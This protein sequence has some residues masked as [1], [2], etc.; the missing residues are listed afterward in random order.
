[1]S[2][3][4]RI[5]S[6]LILAVL[7]CD[8]GKTD[9]LELYIAVVAPARAVDLQFRS[10]GVLVTV[11]AQPGVQVKKG[12]LVAE[13]DTQALQEEL[14][15]AE[16]A[17]RATRA[18]LLQADVDVAD[19][20][21]TFTTEK[22]ATQRGVSAKRSLEKARF[23]RER[24]RAARARAQA[25]VAEQEAR[26]AK[27]RNHLASTRI[28]APFD[29]RIAI[30]YRDPGAMVGPNTPVARLI[31]SEGLRVRFAVPPTQASKLTLGRSVLV[32]V[33]GTANTLNGI[34]RHIAPELDPAS[35]MIFVEAEF[36]KQVDI[37]DIY[38]GSAAWVHIGNI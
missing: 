18:A 32:E 21:Y 27:A 24:A 7:A 1:M 19:A 4:T 3:G 5:V 26:V 6:M 2:P 33:A 13:I 28:H 9:E 37:S 30:R 25:A 16:A 14:A 29:G 20:E 10:A 11:H 38:P 8:T 17:L 22:Q 23:A 36:N 35:K 15:V 34:I 12:S 31:A